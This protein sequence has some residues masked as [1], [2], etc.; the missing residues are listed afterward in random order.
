MTAST[1]SLSP[2]TPTRTSPPK[3]SRSSSHMS[4]SSIRWYGGKIINIVTHTRYLSKM[5]I[6][7]NRIDYFDYIRGIA[8]IMVVAIHTFSLSGTGAE[9]NIKILIRQLLNCAVPLFLA[10]SGY[11]L[12]LKS[13]S[14]DYKHFLKKQVVKVYIPCLIWSLPYFIYN[15]N[16]HDI[17]ISIVLFFTCGYSIYYFIALIMQYYLLLPILQKINGGGII[18]SVIITIISICA[19]TYI[20]AVKGINIPLLLYAGPFPVWLAFFVEG[21]WIGKMKNRDYNIVFWVLL[22][23]LGL[24]FSYIESKMLLPLHNTGVGIKLSSYIYAF[25][26]IMVLF[27]SKVESLFRNNGANKIVTYIGSISF[28]IYLTHIFYIMILRYFINDIGWFILFC[29]TLLLTIVTIFVT[30]KIFPSSVL[31]YIGF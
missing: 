17:L 11:F 4:V 18:I 25:A 24:T 21:I 10:S 27:S 13:K 30:R 16:K 2:T 29:C 12:T 5:L 20:T 22:V 23:C 19:V 9:F 1:A 7:K 26:I 3:S 28:G 14:L 8:I 6:L 31:K 15:L